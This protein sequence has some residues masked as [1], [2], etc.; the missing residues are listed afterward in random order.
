MQNNL[1]LSMFLLPNPV[2]RS[3][4]LKRQTPSDDIIHVY[5]NMPFPYEMG[6]HYHSSEFLNLIKSIHLCLCNDT[7][8][9]GMF[10]I[11]L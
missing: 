3:I 9:S 10:E 5:K 1:M 7:L 8:A 4:Y 2:V 6:N 11:I